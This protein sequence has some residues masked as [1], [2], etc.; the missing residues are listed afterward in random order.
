MKTF[1]DYEQKQCWSTI[2]PIRTKW[3]TT[4]HLKS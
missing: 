3:T 1:Y 2:S 4:S